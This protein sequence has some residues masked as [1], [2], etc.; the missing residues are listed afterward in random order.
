MTP[1]GRVRTPLPRPITADHQGHTRGVGPPLAEDL[2]A[3]ALTPGLDRQACRVP[4]IIVTPV[5]D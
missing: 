5:V 2:G 3:H 1:R 4:H